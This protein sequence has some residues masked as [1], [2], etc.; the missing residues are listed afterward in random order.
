MA[1]APLR[2]SSSVKFSG[3]VRA[4]TSQQEFANIGL[5]LLDVQAL[6]LGDLLIVVTVTLAWLS[7]YLRRQGLGQASEL[8]GV[9]SLYVSIIT[10]LGGLWL[11]WLSLR[12]ARSATQHSPP[13]DNRA[14]FHVQA[15]R[16][17]Y[18]AETM[19]VHQ[20]SDKDCES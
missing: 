4:S 9:I 6:F 15:G 17:S 5:W 7:F 1:A 19:T 2:L 8:A 16:D 20:H 3:L 13:S 14:Q 18:T 12:E 11:G 10:G